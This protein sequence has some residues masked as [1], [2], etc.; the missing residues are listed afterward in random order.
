MFST[1]LGIVLMLCAGSMVHSFPQGAVILEA[2]EPDFVVVEAGDDQEPRQGRLVLETPLDRSEP[3]QAGFR[4]PRPSGRSEDENLEAVIV[5]V[6]DFDDSAPGFEDIPRDRSGSNNAGF[7]LPL[8]ETEDESATETESPVLKAGFTK[9]IRIS[10]VDAAEGDDADFVVVD[11]APEEDLKGRTG[12]ISDIP[13]DL[14]GLKKAG[15]RL[16]LPDD[17]VN[18]DY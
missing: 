7:R 15:F 11:A 4:L 5:E 9:D 16:P 17:Q 6:G 13:R 14:S 3:G 1:N 2:D 12:V 18:F 8:P 10:S